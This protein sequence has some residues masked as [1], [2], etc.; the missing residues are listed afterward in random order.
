MSECTGNGPNNTEQLSLESAEVSEELSHDEASTN[1]IINTGPLTPNSAMLFAGENEVSNFPS[2]PAFLRN[3]L[4]VS[5]LEPQISTS[6]VPVQVGTASH[7]N[8]Q[9]NSS[10]YLIDV[11]TFAPVQPHSFGGSLSF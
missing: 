2:T 8:F 4:P 3:D 9:A 7:P 11:P 10:I 6:L 5:S 1:G